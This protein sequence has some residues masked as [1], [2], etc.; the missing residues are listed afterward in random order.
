MAR[1]RLRSEQLGIIQ[2]DRLDGDLSDIGN[3][4]TL[5][6]L[7]R[8]DQEEIVA[9]YDINV[10]SLTIDNKSVAT[11]EYVDNKTLTFTGDVTGSGTSNIAMTLANVGT[12][13]SYSK[14]TT[15]S[16]GRVTSG[17]DL[18]NSEII[19]YLGFVPANVS[20]T[21]LDNTLTIGVDDGRQ[22]FTSDEY[23]IGKPNRTFSGT[24]TINFYASSGALTPDVKITADTTSLNIEA[25]RLTFNGDDVWFCYDGDI[26]SSNIDVPALNQ[27]LIDEY[28]ASDYHAV[29]YFVAV[30][31]NNIVQTSK[32]LV[33]NDGSSALITEYGTLIF[34]DSMGT[35]D[36]NLVNGNVRLLFTSSINAPIKV[37]SI[38]IGI[39]T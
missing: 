5:G 18:T 36:A 1:T 10:S 20:Y 7:V 37:K 25:S 33:A 26:A 8:I 14:I 16:K 19:S 4:T 2:N 32:L 38:R 23:S 21:Q 9:T 3:L 12:A 27:V 31:N 13:G 24:P 22:Y 35:F 30:I 29:E 6:I 34:G 15:D 39:K 17:R 11:I 28:T